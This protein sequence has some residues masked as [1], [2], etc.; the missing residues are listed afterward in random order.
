MVAGGAPVVGGLYERE[1]ELAALGRALADARAQRGSV[2]VVLGPAGIGKSRL[3]EGAVAAA[4]R[5]GV[6]WFAAVA[7]ERER[8]FPFAVVLQLFERFVR[9]LP[10]A[11]RGEVFAGAG[12]L[13]APLLSAGE[14]LGGLSPQLFALV[15]GLYWFVVNVSE[16]APVLIAVDDAHASDEPSLRFLLYLAQRLAGLPVALVV[17]ARSGEADARPELGELIAGP[18]TRVLRPAPLSPGGARAVIEDQLGF[19]VH[20]E[21]AAACGEVSGGN[22]FL[23]RELLAALAAEGID[24][25][26][27]SVTRVRSLTPGAVTQRLLVRLACL[28][29]VAGALARALAVLGDDVPLRIA[30]AL[31][32][33]EV[34]QAAGAADALA[35]AEILRP[36]AAGEH[37]SFVHP[38]VRA[39]LYED[40]PGGER[41]D[42]HARAALLLI[43][44]RAPPDRIVAHVMR[45]QRG[46]VA[47]SVAL[48][49]DA[50]ADARSRGAPRSAVAFLERAL[51][52][53]AEDRTRA[54][55]ELEL[56]RAQLGAGELE[57]AQQSAR[58]ACALADDR[59]QVAR[60][61]LVRGRALY[62][63][64]RFEDAVGAFEEGLGQLADS[65]EC[66][67]AYELRAGFAE[68]AALDASLAPRG[69]A[70][71]EVIVTRQARDLTFSERALFA[72]LAAKRGCA[73]AP[74]EEVLA[75]AERAWG[76]GALLAGE[77]ADG[78]IWT[79]VT[80]ALACG[81]YL[82][83]DL[84]VCTA[85]LEAAR[86]SGSVLAFA[87]ASFNRSPPLFRLGRVDEAIADAEAAIGARRHGWEQ[88]LGGAA[89]M[90]AHALIEKGELE[91]AAAALA[92]IHEPEMPTRVEYGFLLT[93]RARLGLA[94]GD[95]QAALRDAASAGH[96]FEDVF[97]FRAPLFEAR[98][99]EALAAAGTGDA[100]RARGV[101]EEL[102]ELTRSIGAPG[103]IGHG[104][105]V[106]GLVERGARGLELFAEAVSVLEPA[107]PRLEHIRALVDFGAALR[108]AGHRRGAR[109]P[110][111]RGLEL[112]AHG[113]A[114]ALAARARAELAALGARPRK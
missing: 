79:L 65:E 3:V 51:E 12:A 84:E 102:L 80:F 77:G 112:A 58:R 28:P 21:F 18:P 15:H 20:G 71:A 63:G 109:E 31:G 87:L 91:A 66:E 44:E 30:A 54:H 72:Q 1:R 73:A 42:A 69:L 100:A 114:L 64:G 53:P 17:A 76:D 92:P 33:V 67:L 90:L 55:L 24:E 41:A 23:L 22:P 93:A 49:S 25:G 108:H 11:E 43:A 26:T 81:D 74:R 96:L 105:R 101:A 4:R 94:R 70:M 13:A 35:S 34:G 68:V 10:L 46:V 111:E 78:T 103:M 82:E 36:L 106:L 38:L 45:A 9:G 52:E 7:G 16:R 40:Q 83:R 85:A 88:H 32:N 5:G 56:A 14:G 27:V 29:D 110:L 47:Q 75:L 2:V 86:A 104:L 59:E 39:A 57:G 19:A 113:G 50:A 99:T 107:A 48:L 97:G 61:Q 62:A 8:E 89:A 6:V 98:S 60:A 95:P 37:V